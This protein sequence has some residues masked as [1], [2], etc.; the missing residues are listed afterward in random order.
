MSPTGVVV[1]IS[2]VWSSG[3]D[4]PEISSASPAAKSS[5]PSITE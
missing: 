2:S 4:S 1:V 3:A 5:K